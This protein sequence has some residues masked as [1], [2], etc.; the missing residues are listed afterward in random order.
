L[1]LLIKD[2]QFSVCSTALRKAGV[3]GISLFTYILAVQ[4]P[5]LKGQH[6]RTGRNTLQP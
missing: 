4:L 3:I 6:E 2:M 5:L 1:L